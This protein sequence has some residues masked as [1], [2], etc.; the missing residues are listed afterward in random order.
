MIFSRVKSKTG[1]FRA[2]TQLDSDGETDRRVGS[3]QLERNYSNTYLCL[4]GQTKPAIG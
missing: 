3:L 1:K 4:C 2:E